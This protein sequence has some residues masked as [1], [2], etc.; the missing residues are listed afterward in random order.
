MIVINFQEIKST[1]INITVTVNAYRYEIQYHDLNVS[2]RSEENTKWFFDN[3]TEYLDSLLIIQEKVASR[4]TEEVEEV[5]RQV[6]IP[7]SDSRSNIRV[8]RNRKH[9]LILS[10]K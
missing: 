3:M 9:A 1:G 7:L 8:D 5:L 4:I 2:Y 6:C 10:S